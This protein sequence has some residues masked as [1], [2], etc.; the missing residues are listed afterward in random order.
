MGHR[1]ELGR[2]WRIPAKKHYRI[3]GGWPDSLAAGPDDT[4]WVGQGNIGQ[5]TR[6][7]VGRRHRH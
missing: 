6:L 2:I 4:L 5:V 1:L 3:P 7:D